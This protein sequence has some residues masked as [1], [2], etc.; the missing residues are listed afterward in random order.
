MYN[1]I[2]GQWVMR[3]VT[4]EWVQSKVPTRITQEQC[5]TILATPQI[6]G[7]MPLNAVTSTI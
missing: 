1:Y 4:A 6:L 7:T 5:D 2:L 3:A